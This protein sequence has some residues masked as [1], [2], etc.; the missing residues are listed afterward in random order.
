MKIQKLKARAYSYGGKRAL[1]TVIGIVIHYTGNSND[2]AEANAKYFAY[3]NTR[4]AGAHF[5]V[6]RSGNIWQSVPMNRIAWSV[7]CIYTTKNGAGKYYKILTNSNT[8]SIELCDIAKRDPSPAQI[9][10][11]R[12]LV[13][14][15][16]KQCPNAKRIV[17]HWD[18]NGKLC[19]YRMVGVDNPKWQTFLSEITGGTVTKPKAKTKTTTANLN[20]RT[21]ASTKYRVLITMPKGSTVTVL[22]SGKNWSKVK[23]K[24]KVGWCSNAY[25]K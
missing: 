21:G 1:F 6:D 17:R 5:F 22:E 25:L 20:L 2:T 19:P 10:A 9:K 11:T 4:S 15:I 18:V 12:E 8:V 14:Y 3:T 7:G 16:Q 13:A 24:N 23:Y